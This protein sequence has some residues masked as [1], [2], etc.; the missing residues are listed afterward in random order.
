MRKNKN[1]YKMILDIVMTIII[2]LL[3]KTAF[4]GIKLHEIFGIAAFTLFLIHKLINIKLIKNMFNK[5]SNKNIVQKFIIITD[6]FLLID[7]FIIIVTGVLI[8]QYIFNN[9]L[10]I[11]NLSIYSAVHHGSAYLGMLLISVHIGLHWNFIINMLKKIFK[12]KYISAFRTIVLRITTVII[13]LLGIKASFNQNVLSNLIEPFYISNNNMS[14]SSTGAYNDN[15][16]TEYTASEDQ[17]DT[18]TPTNITVVAA[19]SLEEYL[20]SL[21]CTLCPKHCPLSSPMCSKG[22]VPAQ[23]ATADYYSLYDSSS[24]SADNSLTENDKEDNNIND[25]ENSKSESSYN[26]NGKHHSYETSKEDDNSNTTESNDENEVI[27]DTTASDKFPIE[28]A[29]D[30]VSIMGLYIGGTHYLVKIPRKK[31]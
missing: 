2:I 16:S 25:E 12:V 22:E 1:L 24:A 18:I 26:G 9:A 7:I 6:L 5:F 8:S 15:Q 30:Y 11:S 21:F 19:P 23:K 14:Q 28:N 17:S 20:S 4:T 29:F 3:M 31:K 27:T 13:M 10:S